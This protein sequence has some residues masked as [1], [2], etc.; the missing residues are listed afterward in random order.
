MNGWSYERSLI[1][2][3]GA[4]ISLNILGTESILYISVP[5]LAERTLPPLCHHKCSTF[6]TVK[7]VDT[8]KYMCASKDC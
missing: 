6:F 1:E 2:D 5:V 4:R 3:S 8:E 7:Q